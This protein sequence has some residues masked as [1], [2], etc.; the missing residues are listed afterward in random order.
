MYK[1]IFKLAYTKNIFVYIYKFSERLSRYISANIERQLNPK[2]TAILR[3]N[4]SIPLWRI[5]S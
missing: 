2:Q 1:L 4:K 5:A 3:P